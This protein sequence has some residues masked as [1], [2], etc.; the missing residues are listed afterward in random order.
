MVDPPKDRRV[1]SGKWIFKLKRGPGGE[2]VRY[3]CR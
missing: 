3:K 2:I 1:L